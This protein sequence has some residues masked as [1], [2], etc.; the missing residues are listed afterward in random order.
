MGDEAVAVIEQAGTDGGPALEK[1]E[2]GYTSQSSHPTIT[3]EQMNGRGLPCTVYISR[4]IGRRCWCIGSRTG[5][6][7]RR[8]SFT[9]INHPA[10]SRRHM[11]TYVVVGAIAHLHGCC[12]GLGA[13]RLFLRKLGRDVT[14][15]LPERR[16]AGQEARGSNGGEGLEARR[17]CQFVRLFQRLE[18]NEREEKV[19]RSR[20]ESTFPRGSRD[21]YMYF[22]GMLAS[23][24]S[25]REER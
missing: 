10:A 16:E 24:T 20:H 7:K 6:P 12:F 9:T 14:L 22:C 19:V 23:G 4:Q 25:R 17:G 13:R 21:R 2:G 8:V 15:G 5:T 1:L 18:G 11:H 3:N